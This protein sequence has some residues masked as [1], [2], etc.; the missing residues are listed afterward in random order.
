MLR[1]SQL[2]CLFTM[3]AAW[4]ACTE[5][6]TQ[7]QTPSRQLV[8][9]SQC[10]DSVTTVCGPEGCD[11]FFNF[12]E[13]DAG[14]TGGFGYGDPGWGAGGGGSGGGGSDPEDEFTDYEYVDCNPGLS[15]TPFSSSSTFEGKVLATTQCTKVVED[16][17]HVVQ[18]TLTQLFP[19][20]ELD[21]ETYHDSK[22]NTANHSTLIGLDIDQALGS[23]RADASSSHR[24][25]L[26]ASQFNP[27]FSGGPGSTGSYS[28]NA[29]YTFN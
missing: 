4:Y 21:D 8:L 13:C 23:V 27:Y 26:L 24:V 16:I 12:S 3:I 2:L 28:E 1:L 29:T 9:S 14:S 11:S 20:Q 15:I 7:P 18:V 22:T 17:V 19:S 25:N 10:L 6:P 5:S